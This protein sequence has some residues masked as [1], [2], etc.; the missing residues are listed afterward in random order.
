[1]E[2]EVAIMYLLLSFLSYETRKAALLRRRA[3]NEKGQIERQKIPCHYYL[4]LC[5]DCVSMLSRNTALVSGC[6]SLGTVVFAR[7]IY[8][9]G[10][11]D[12]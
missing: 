12:K 10:L 5:L 4:F 2:S 1:M 6:F 3:C 7:E 8:P 11:V 9:Q